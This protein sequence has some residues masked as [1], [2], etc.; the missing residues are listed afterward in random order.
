MA[1]RARWSEWA[2]AC[3]AIAQTTG[4]RARAMPAAMPRTTQPV[5]FRTRS[6]VTP[7]ATATHRAENRF[8]RKAGSPNGCRTTDANQ[9]SST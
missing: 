4:V 5:S 7:A 1:R 9:P 3:V 8:I 6:T 2:S